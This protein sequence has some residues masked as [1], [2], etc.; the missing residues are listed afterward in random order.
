[1]A[2]WYHGV[3]VPCMYYYYMVLHA[4]CY[5]DKDMVPYMYRTGHGT[6]DE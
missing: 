4:Y 2:S 6:A 1:M 3:M 5:V